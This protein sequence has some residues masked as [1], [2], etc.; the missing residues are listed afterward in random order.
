MNFNRFIEN[1]HGLLQAGY[2]SLSDKELDHFN[3]C[4]EPTI[5]GGLAMR[6]QQ[7]IDAGK[8][9][10][11][12]RAWWITGPKLHCISRCKSSLR[13]RSESCPI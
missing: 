9:P 13:Q 3:R 10:G 8:L 11:I 5:T 12:S 2:T 1:V 6:I 4:D 7:L